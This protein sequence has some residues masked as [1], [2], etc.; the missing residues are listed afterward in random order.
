[1]QYLIYG[2][3]HGAQMVQPAVVA[4]AVGYPRFTSSSDTKQNHTVKITVK[5]RAKS[6]VVVLPVTTDLDNVALFAECRDARIVG[7]PECLGG[8]SV[9]G[10]GCSLTLAVAAR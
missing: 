10:D 1:M 6:V 4:Y 8:R 7:S 5:S 3:R 9:P 2:R